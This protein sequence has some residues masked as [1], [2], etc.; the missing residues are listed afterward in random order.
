MLNTIKE[1]PARTYILIV[2]A[3]LIIGG[4]FY[5]F[6]E[7]GEEV[8]ENEMFMIDRYAADFAESLATPGVTTFFAW[9]TELGSVWA[10]TLGS[11]IMLVVLWVFYQR[12]KWRIVYFV[13]AMGGVTLLIAGLKAAFSRDRPN[14]IDAYDGTGYSFPSGHSTAPIVFY[15]FIIYLVMR[16]KLNAL[17]KWLINIFL[18]ILILLIAFSRLPLGVHYFTDVIGGLSLGLTWL[19]SCIAILEITLWHTGRKAGKSKIS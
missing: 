13:I 9:I 10:L 18:G 8:L 15:G 16:S 1:I 19:V 4:G 6:S 7:L 14:I 5:I 12:K 2:T 11:I 17:A 3:L